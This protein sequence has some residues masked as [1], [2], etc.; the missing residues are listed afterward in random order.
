MRRGRRN[1]LPVNQTPIISGP[2]RRSAVDDLERVSRAA[3]SVGSR[4]RIE[5]EL[6][7]DDVP[8]VYFNTLDLGPGHSGGHQPE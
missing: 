3:G 4:D 2:L 5:T 6:V 7:G 8:Q 1:P